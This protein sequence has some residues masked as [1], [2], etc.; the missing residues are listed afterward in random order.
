MIKLVVFLVSIFSPLLVGS[1]QLGKIET[2]CLASSVV[3]QKQ[4]VYFMA[5]KSNIEGSSCILEISG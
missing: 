1:I 2:A 3:S 5:F 4:K